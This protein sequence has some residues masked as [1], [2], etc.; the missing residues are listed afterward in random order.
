MIAFLAALGRL[1]GGLWRGY[2]DPEFRALFF[3]VGM[4]LLGGTLFYRKFEGWSALDSLYFSFV[5]LT[6]IGY[7]DLS[8]T[9]PFSKIFTMLFSLGGIGV[10]LAFVDKMGGKIFEA[11][12]E[13]FAGK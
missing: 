10:L 5:T 6:T 8:P 2:R 4:L 11:R 3:L 13:R 12:R 9:T 1:L 7:G